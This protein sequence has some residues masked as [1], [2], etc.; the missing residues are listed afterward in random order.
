M[1]LGPGGTF[2][3]SSEYVLFGR[4]GTLK[5]LRR[6]DSTWFNWRRMDRQHSRKPDA[7]LNLVEQVSPSPR[8]ELFSRRARFGWDYPIGDQATQRRGGMMVTRN[9]AE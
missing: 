6:C 3:Q 2:A 5:H 4:I 8:C 9:G 1:G 7:F